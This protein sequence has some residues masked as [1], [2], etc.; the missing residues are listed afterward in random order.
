MLIDNELQEL[1]KEVLP[2]WSLENAQLTH[3][4]SSENVTFRVEK[5]GQTYVLRIHRSWYHTRDELESELVWTKALRASG[6]D[7]PEP[8]LTNSGE[9]FVT[10]PLPGTDEMRNIGVLKWVEGDNLADVLR[11]D[12]SDLETVSSYFERLGAI[13]ASM[14]SQA[15]AWDVPDAFTRHSFDVEG[16][17]GKRPFWGRFWELPQLK[18]EQTKLMLKARDVIATTLASYRKPKET[19]SM[20]HGDL[21][22]QN[23]I[24]GEQG[25]HVIDFDDAGFGWHQYDLATALH[26]Y[27][28]HKEYSAIVSALLKGYRNHRALDAEAEASLPMFLLIRTLVGLGWIHQRPELGR[29]QHIPSKIEKAC[30][31]IEQFFSD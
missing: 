7:V 12:S 22:M 16:F 8:L 2:E 31:H 18:P 5:N 9:G 29:E 30:H 3:V 4:K 11:R 24:V 6:I 13:A 23:L 15:A 25:L 26:E 14:H 21:H 27:S 1:A 17:V 28:G 20:I 19:Y 10:R